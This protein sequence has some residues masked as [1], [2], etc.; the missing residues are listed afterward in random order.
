MLKV[1]CNFEVESFHETF[2][3]Y[4]LDCDDGSM[5]LRVGSKLDG[6]PDVRV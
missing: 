1:L 6:S 3:R 4:E 2:S 5:G